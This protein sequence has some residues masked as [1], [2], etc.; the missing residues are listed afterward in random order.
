MKL[1]NQL[2][3]RVVFSIILS[4]IYVLVSNLWS[5][6]FRF[7]FFTLLVVAV[8]I[9]IPLTVLWAIISTFLINDK[10]QGDNDILD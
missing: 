2:K 1:L 5:E 6:E 9:Y 10:E 8:I 4:G 7:D 3:Y